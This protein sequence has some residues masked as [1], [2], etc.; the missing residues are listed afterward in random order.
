MNKEVF[1][2]V[3]NPGNSY[4]NLYYH[5]ASNCYFIF[6]GVFYDTDTDPTL[7]H[8]NQIPNNDL[9]I[10]VTMNGNPDG[11]LKLFTELIIL[12]AP[13]PDGNTA[14][15]VILNVAGSEKKKTW[16]SAIIKILIN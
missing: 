1:Q 6:I 7:M 10:D 9:K 8:D 15:E 5:H 2:S 16:A 12:P 11:T 4:I 14:G 13:P 3:C